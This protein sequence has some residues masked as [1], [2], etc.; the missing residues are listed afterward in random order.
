M[1][2]EQSVP[3][4]PQNRY[5]LTKGTALQS[6]LWDVFVNQLKAFLNNH[7][8]LPMILLLHLAKIKEPRVGSLEHGGHVPSISFFHHFRE[9]IMTTQRKEK[10][11]EAQREEKVEKANDLIMV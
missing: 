4:I 9:K 6:T 11:R 5:R 8:G 10:K 7:N 1:V 3:E 2:K